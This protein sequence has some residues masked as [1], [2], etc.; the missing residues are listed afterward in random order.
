MS[1]FN[2]LKSLGL[3]SEK[4]RYLFNEKTRDN[5]DLKVWKDSESGV[6]FIDDYFT[7]EQTYESGEYR[8]EKITI[9]G[10]P[11][12]E[13]FYDAKRR[14]EKNYK[15]LV[16]KSVLDYG[17][18]SGEFLNLIRG[19]TNYICGVEL[20]KDYRNQLNE[21]G[22]DCFK[23]LTSIQE[24][25]LDVCTSF[26]VIEHL[27]DPIEILAEI[28]KKIKDKGLLII[29]VPHANDFLLSTAIVEEFKQFTLWS[30]HLILHTRTSLFKILNSAGFRNIII[31]G[32]QRYTISNHINW[33]LKGEPGGHKSTFSVFEN[34]N[35][36][37]A[38][39]DALSRIDSTDTLVAY[40][41]I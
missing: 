6:I 4:T 20:Q 32:V 30:Q 40:A 23:N 8:K 21:V 22:I 14:S 17:C 25:S 26:H 29:E 41:S 27:L 3:T 24:K 38:Y 13:R 37:I 28:R 5:S 7:G 34:E 11:N 31:E 19:N 12:Y 39:A 18:G 1:I 33:M 10:N 15:Y 2:L 9:T 35:L 36:N 16:G